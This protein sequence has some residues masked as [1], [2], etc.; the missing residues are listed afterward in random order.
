GTT[1][2][3]PRTS[4]YK[5]R[6]TAARVSAPRQPADRVHIHHIPCG[7]RL[8]S[9]VFRLPTS[10]FRVPASDFR[11][12][13]SDSLQNPFDGQEVPIEQP[14]AKSDPEGGE[15]P[16]ADDD[17]GLRPALQ[18]EVEVDGCHAEDPLAGETETRH[19]QHHRQRLGDEDPADDHEEEMGVGQEGEGGE[20][21]ADR[22]GA[23]VAHEDLRRR[24]VP[25]QEAEEG[26]EHGRREGGQLEGIDRFVD[27]V[28][29]GVAELPEGDDGVGAHD[30]GTGPAGEPVHA[31]GEVHTVGGAGQHDKHPDEEEGAEID[32]ERTDERHLG[33]HIGGGGAHRE[34]DGDDELGAELGSLA[35]PEG[36]LVGELDVVVDE[37]DH[38][39]ADERHHRQE[40]PGA[41]R[42]QLEG[43][44]GGGGPDAQVGD[45]VPDE[46]GEHEDDAPHR[47]RA[48]L[49]GVL[50][51]DVVLDELAD[52]TTTEEPDGVGSAE[53]RHDQG[54]RGPDEERDHGSILPCSMSASRA[55]SRSSNGRIRPCTSWPRSWPRPRIKTTSP[56]RAISMAA[57]IASR[58]STRRRTRD[59]SSTPDTTSSMIASGG[60][61]RGLSEVTI[62]S[63]AAIASH[64]IW[65]RFARSR[66]PPAPNTTIRRRVPP[67]ETHSPR[68]VS[69]TEAMALAMLAGVWA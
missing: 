15:D 44:A 21:A 28:G 14:K 4:T 58:R 2:Q 62:T 9:S 68:P 17:G 46:A 10:D 16:E 56:S 13:S 8:P 27:A 52:L 63:S 38:G 35:Q 6:K 43:E 37:T 7:F 45:E 59:G 49:V 23:D 47:R 41:E 57:P 31:V 25:P 32:A 53:D 51:L 5:H 40:A 11:L 55:T 26:G 50:A 24:G 36:A 66:S 12:P 64:P 1:P 39:H 65:G 61:L 48:L 18:V 34:E 60:S 22:L 29:G 54:D 3:T 20:E 42:E 33:D 30:Q 67:S 19:L 69:R